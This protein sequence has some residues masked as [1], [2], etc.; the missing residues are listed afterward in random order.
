MILWRNVQLL[1]HCTFIQN[2]TKLLTRAEQLWVLGDSNQTASF[3]S[4]VVSR[5][6][7]VPQKKAVCLNDARVFVL[8]LWERNLWLLAR[9]PRS[10]RGLSVQ[11]RKEQWGVV[12]SEAWVQVPDKV[13]RCGAFGSFRH[14]HTH[15]AFPLISEEREPPLHVHNRSAFPFPLSPHSHLFGRWNQNSSHL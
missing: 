3:N 8:Q 6:N 12:F 10:E 5:N 4:V 2:S 1:I 9:Q 7:T 13:V 14:T 15:T 11:I